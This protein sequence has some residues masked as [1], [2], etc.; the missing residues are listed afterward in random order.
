MMLE[1]INNRNNIEYVRHLN[2][3]LRKNIIVI[4][5][6]MQSNIFRCNDLFTTT[7][8]YQTSHRFLTHEKSSMK[9]KKYFKK[10]KEIYLFHF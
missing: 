1:N 10:I 7:T 4:K 3:K 5:T 9:A 2:E 8:I 6:I